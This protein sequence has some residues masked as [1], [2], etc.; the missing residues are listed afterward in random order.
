MAEPAFK[1]NE[2]EVGA[3]RGVEVAEDTAPG[4]AVPHTVAS[5]LRCLGLTNGDGLA[6][7]AV[8]FGGGDAGGELVSD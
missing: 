7:V 4:P 5:P 2:I 1:V 3:R 8:N 6:A